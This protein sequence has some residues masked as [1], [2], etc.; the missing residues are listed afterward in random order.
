MVGEK[1][2]PA[3][4]N[5]PGQ[6]KLAMGQPRSRRKEIDIDEQTRC[7][8]VTNR[9]LGAFHQDKWAFASLTNALEQG[10]NREHGKRG[11]PRLRH[12]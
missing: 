5:E 1:L 9:D 7:S 2:R 6:Q 10:S 4:F 12:Q 3:G 8:R 11:H